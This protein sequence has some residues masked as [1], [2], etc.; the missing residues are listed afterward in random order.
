[1]Q[2]SLYWFRQDL[3]LADNPALS[4]AAKQG[5]I[6]PVYI[7][8]ETC[9]KQYAMGAASRCWL[10]HSLLA[11][12][13]QLNN[14]LILKKGDPLTILVQ[15]IKTHGITHVYW[16][17][18]YT[19]WQIKRD[20]KI[21]KILTQQHGIAIHTDNSALLLEP[22]QIQNKT[23]KHYRIFTPFYRTALTQLATPQPVI[24]KPRQLRF[25][26]TQSAKTTLNQLRL[27][28]NKPWD[29][30]MMAAWQASEQGAKN[31]LTAFI[32]TSLPQYNV[33]R[34]F[35][36][37]P[38]CSTLSAYLH[39]GQISPNQIWQRIMQQQKNDNTTGFLRQLLWRDFAYHLLYHH[40]HLATDNLQSTFDRFAWQNKPSWLKAWQHGQTGYPLIDAGMRQLWQT[41]FMHNRLRMLVA[42]FLVKHLRIDWRKG[43]A[44][45]WDCLI[46]ADMANNS[47]GWQWVAGCGTDAAP[48]FRI[49]N[50][51]TQ[52]KKFDP[53]GEY[54]RQYVPELANLPL[55]Y[56][57]APWMAPTSV[58]ETAGISL[59][60]TY[61]RPIVDHDTARNQALSAF[62]KL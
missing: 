27:L 12:Q 47:A 43:A 34:D 20:Q 7:V 35:P 59:G 18:C 26:S 17:R 48:Y 2:R 45:F 49:F 57:F 56:L 19:P 51:I 31:Q 28:P 53:N 40:P 46:D 44:W 25:L 32:K 5:A 61:P 4:L 50:P 15:L 33:H 52:G 60:K 9:P 16:S 13:N 10:H 39:F 21:E 54:T 8:D 41:G 58:L 23:G 38:A 30:S 1:M 29:K 37:I 6:L 62:K 42:S 22:W 3:R 11:L 24:Q 36:A 55:Q 14:H